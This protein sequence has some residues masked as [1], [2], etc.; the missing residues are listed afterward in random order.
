MARYAIGDL[1]GCWEELKRLLDA[2]A[3]DSAA[4]Q[5]YLV[6]DLVNRGPG[7]LEVLRW[8]HRHPDSVFA[9]LGNHDLHLLACYAGHGTLKESDTLAEVLAAPDADQ[10]CDWLRKQPLLRVLP[11]AVIVHAGLWPFWHRE[12]ATA[13][14]AEVESALCA[15]DWQVFLA[16]MYGNK[17]AH[18]EQARTPADRARF[19]IN[20]A[21]RMRFVDASGAL[22]LKFKGELDQ[23]PP[24]LVPWF[25]APGRNRWGRVVCGHWSALGLLMRDDL[26]AIDTGCVWGGRLTA[27]CLDDA[28]VMQV[29]ADRSYQ[30]IGQ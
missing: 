19:T 2:V 29:A 20:A 22:Q 11:D 14:C 13:A 24:E 28:R 3:F 25:D 4:D 23:A 1:Q 9:V 16:D 18:W 17:P 15:P 27:V 5:L 12:H 10:L 7:S 8:A 26:W 30:E 21:T 6:G